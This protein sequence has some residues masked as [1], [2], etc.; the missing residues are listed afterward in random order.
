M[1]WFKHQSD[2]YS[3]LK[4]QQVLADYGLSGY[5]F[6]WVC[7][8][9]IAQ[10]GINNRIKSDKNW[11]KT[12]SFITR[13]SEEEIEKLLFS[14]AS[15]GLIDEKALKN[16]DLFIPKMRDYSDEYTDKIRRKSRQGR[17]N[18]GLEEKRI[19]KNRREEETPLIRSI[20]YLSELPENDLQ[21]FTTRFVARSEEVKSKAEDLR[22]YCEQ[23]GKKYLNY[24]SFLINALK[25]DFKERANIPAAQQKKCVVCGKEGGSGWMQTPKGQVHIDCRK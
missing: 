13:E 10:Q 2:A 16:K 21:E 23:K 24:R 4:H 14:F 8:E 7:V 11:K 1:K 17:D 22:L 19:D 6:F 18:V 5:G 9:F 12:L 3:N 15:V 20:K 25:R